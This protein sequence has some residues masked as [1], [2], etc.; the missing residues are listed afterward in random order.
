MGSFVTDQSL[1]TADLEL[2]TTA[3]RGDKLALRLVCHRFRTPL[4]A[5]VLHKTGDW[6]GAPAAAETV[7]EQLCR[8]L[9]SGILL[10]C[11]WASRAMELGAEQSTTVPAAPENGSGLEGLAAIARVA[12][13]RTL[14]GL[15]PQLPL[16]ELMALLLAYVDG[17]RGHEMAG[18]V[19]ETPA[20]AA[21]CLLAAHESAKAALRPLSTAGETQ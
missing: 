17:R 13:R 19:A 11:D 14:R 2:L 8:E 3:R 9:L 21:G 18:L 7:L 6:E 20:E 4:L 12:K 10:P 16:P 1:C 5:I 15:L